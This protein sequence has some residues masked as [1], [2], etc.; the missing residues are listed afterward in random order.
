MNA[1]S[2]LRRLTAGT[3]LAT[4]ALTALA[5]AAQAGHGNGSFRKVRRFERSDHAR[6]VVH[7]PRR[8]VEFRRSSGGGSTLAGFL[9]GLAVGAI[10]ASASDAHARAVCDAPA[11]YAAP[12]P[13]DC[14]PQDDYSYIDPNLHERFASLDLYMA[15]ARRH[16]LQTWVVQVIDNRDGNCVDTIRY[17]DG[18]WQSCGRGGHDDRGY[19][20]RGDDGGRG[21]DGDNGGD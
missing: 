21:D 13:S 6:R 5:P 12:P 9:G 4:L 18:G 8:V 2:T 7:A 19:D 11:A 1:H 17:G 10:L 3:L 14:L 15:F 20:N 16:H